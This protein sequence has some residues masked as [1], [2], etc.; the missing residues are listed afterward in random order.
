M[1]TYEEEDCLVHSYSAMKMKE[2]KNR[3]KDRLVVAF[4]ELSKFK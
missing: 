3:E 1:I 2:L 4:T